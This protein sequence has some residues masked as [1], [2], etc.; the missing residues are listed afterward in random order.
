MS[1]DKWSSSILGMNN[2]DALTPQCVVREWEQSPLGPCWHGLCSYLE[3]RDYSPPSLR[4]HPCVM[5]QYTQLIKTGNCFLEIKS[6]TNLISKSLGLS[7]R[8]RPVLFH[9]QIF[10]PHSR[11]INMCKGRT[12]WD[13]VSHD[14]RIARCP[15]QRALLFDFYRRCALSHI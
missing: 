8:Y 11:R 9:D 12:R 1:G 15:T 14:P 3:R 13:C 6:E 5:L 10:G 4:A 7:L 2:V